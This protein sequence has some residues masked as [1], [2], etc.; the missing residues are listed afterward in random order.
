[1]QTERITTLHENITARKVLLLIDGKEELINYDELLERFGV[2]GVVRIPEDEFNTMNDESKLFGHFNLEKTNHEIGAKYLI[3]KMLRNG[4]YGD[5]KEAEIPPLLSL[6][7]AYIVECLEAENHLPYSQLSSNY[8]DHSIPN[9]TDE[10]TLQLAVLK[11]YSQSRKNLPEEEI[12]SKGVAFTLFKIMGQLEEESALTRI[13]IDD[14]FTEYPTESTY[15]NKVFTKDGR[16]Y[17][18]N[19]SN[20]IERQVTDFDTLRKKLIGYEDRIPESHISA[21][22]YGNQL[23]TCVSQKMING[24][25]LKK[26]TPEELENALKTPENKKFITALLEYFF[27]AID[28]KELYPDPVG[29]PANP[30]FSNSVNLMLDTA[31]QKIILCDI[32]LSPHGDS[33]KKHGDSF[34][35]SQNVITYLEK[36]RKFQ[37]TL[38]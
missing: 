5:E 23:Y 29:Y 6:D 10:S 31:S 7:G 30:E 8:F 16:I 33:I 2:Q 18:L 1:M 3:V 19:K 21:C 26:L 11:R 36:M 9:I 38:S 15:S 25:E 37:E 24:K 27:S 28:A 20:S 34:Y 35:Q 12:I 17:K 32:G 22:E 14:G 13:S 4:E